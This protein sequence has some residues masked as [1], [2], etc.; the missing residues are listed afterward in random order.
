[1]YAKINGPERRLTSFER[2]PV[3][4][5]Y[6]VT[7]TMHRSPCLHEQNHDAVCSCLFLFLICQ[8]N[9][10]WDDCLAKLTN[11]QSLTL[12]RC[13]LAEET[14]NSDLSN[15]TA[16]TALNIIQSNL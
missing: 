11:L 8:C 3:A 2:A 10:G 1:M 12:T 7:L 13:N 16:L 6:F 14:L 15:L 9:A 5:I 4:P